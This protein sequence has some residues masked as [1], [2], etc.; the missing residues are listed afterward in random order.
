M[1]IQKMLKE[2]LKYSECLYKIKLFK[3]ENNEI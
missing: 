1:K 2:L 3:G